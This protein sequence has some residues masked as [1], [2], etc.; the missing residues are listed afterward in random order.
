MGEKSNIPVLGSNFLTGASI[1][2]VI[3]NN[4]LLTESFPLGDIQD[5]KTLPKIA[6]V[7][8]VDSK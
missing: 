3:L 4:K 6:N 8:T 1:G 5:I 2:S 7:N